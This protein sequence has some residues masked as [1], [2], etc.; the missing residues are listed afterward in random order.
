MHIDACI[1]TH[2]HTHADRLVSF[3]RIAQGKLKPA[4]QLALL[5][6]SRQDRDS[7]TRGVRV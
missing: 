6:E 1:H 3:R 5:G 7:Q 4:V 2:T